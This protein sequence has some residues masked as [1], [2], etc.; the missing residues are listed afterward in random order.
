MTLLIIGG[1]GTLGRQLVRKALAKGLKVR[2]IVRN[3]QN[4][5]YLEKWGAELVYGDLA[6]PETLV[7]S[8][9]G[10]T[11]VIDVSTTRPEDENNMFDIDWLGK[12]ILIELAKRVN[13]KHFI[14]FSIFNAEKYLYISLM[15]MKANIEN[16]LKNSGVP[17]TIFQCGGFYQALIDQY[18]I[19]VIEQKPIW[20]TKEATPVSY[21][22][23]Q[24]AALFCLKSLSIE[25]TKNCTFFLGVE[26][27]WLSQ[28]IITLCEQ[29]SGQKAVIQFVPLFV[30][31]LVR[32]IT[33][34]FSW[35]SKISDRLAFIEVLIDNAKFVSSVSILYKTFDI[36]SDELLPLEEYLRQ[37]F[38]L[39]VVTLEKFHVGK[40][41]TPKD[42]VKMR[43]PEDS[44]MDYKIK[45]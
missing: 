16:V 44:R 23:T 6:L 29:L 14:F 33:G 42:L 34:F 25:K 8:F 39:I 32:Q 40:N 38:E 11:S 35:S 27:S 37:Y 19:P 28:N 43:T 3:K 18:A 5:N 4:A 7:L 22:D 9:Q 41:M 2:C 17:Y 10:V 13:V 24:D 20:I 26:N 15:R 31:R 36:K 30:V 12:L 1:T 45:F 21:I